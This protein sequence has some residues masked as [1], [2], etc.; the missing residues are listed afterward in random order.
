MARANVEWLAGR[1]G[2]AR[3]YY[4]AAVQLLGE[5]NANAGAFDHLELAL[6]HARLG[7]GAAAGKENEE[8][9]GIDRRSHDMSGVETERR[10]TL[11]W[12]QLALGN[13]AGAIELLE[14]TLARKAHGYLLSPAL[15]RIDPTWDP[16][17]HDPRFRALLKKY[18]KPEP[19]SAATAAATASVVA[20]GA[21]NA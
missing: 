12:T 19:A 11:A 2:D 20:G 17:R 4:H 13:P 18:S 1:Q 16:I 7:E 15:L 10:A 14:K 5:P 3:K 8:A 21:G 6:A 9:A